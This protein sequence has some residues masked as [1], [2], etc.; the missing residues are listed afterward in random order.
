MPRKELKPITEAE[1]KIQI[2]GTVEQNEEK[3]SK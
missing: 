1:E 3:E 2:E